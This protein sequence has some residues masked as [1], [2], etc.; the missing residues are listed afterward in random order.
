MSLFIICRGYKLCN[1]LR[2]VYFIV[3]TWIHMWLFNTCLLFSSLFLFIF[4]RVAPF[5]IH[6]FFWCFSL[7]FTLC[8]YHLSSCV[9]EDFGAWHFQMKLRRSATLLS[10]PLKLYI[11]NFTYLK[12]KLNKK[13]LKQNL[14]H[15]HNDIKCENF[16]IKY[17]VCQKYR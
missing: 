10:F 15:M 4:F 16:F 2:N 3:Y 6:K 1:K 14:S 17:Y 12:E 8:M 5:C 11:F 13:F 9:L 7:F